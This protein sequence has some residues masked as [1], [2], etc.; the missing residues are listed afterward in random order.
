[1]AIDQ[2]IETILSPHRTTASYRL[3]QLVEVTRVH[4]TNGAS[5]LTGRKTLYLGEIVALPEIQSDSEQ[6]PNVASYFMLKTTAKEI[7]DTVVAVDGS[8]CSTS[9]AVPPVDLVFDSGHELYSMKP[10]EVPLP[11]Q[12]QN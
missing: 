12:R 1:M 7:V 8:T 3:G 11:I 5:Q 2:G 10:Q 9:H 6:N 4:L